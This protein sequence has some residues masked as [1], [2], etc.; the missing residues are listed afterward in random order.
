MSLLSTPCD[1]VGG[2][3][4]PHPFPPQ[5]DLKSSLGGWT[6]KQNGNVAGCC[7]SSRVSLTVLLPTVSLQAIFDR[8]NE[9]PYAQGSACTEN[10]LCPE[11]LSSWISSPT[12]QSPINQAVS[13]LYNTHTSEASPTACPTS[14]SSPSFYLSAAP[15]SLLPEKGG[16]KNRIFLT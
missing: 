7:R 9:L 10:S 4:S 5:R 14:P 12:L 16:G 11:P 15:V 1:L 8:K 3:F 6:M 13:M 2:F